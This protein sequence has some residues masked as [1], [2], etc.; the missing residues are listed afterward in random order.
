MSK[1]YIADS[2]NDCFSFFSYLRNKSV[3]TISQNLQIYPR[4]FC[5]IQEEAV[6]S[7]WMLLATPMRTTLRRGQ[8]FPWKSQS[9]WHRTRINIRPW[10]GHTYPKS[11][12]S[13]QLHYAFIGHTRQHHDLIGCSETRT[14]GAHSASALW[15][16]SLE[17]TFSELEFRYDT[18][19]DVI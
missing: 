5:K 13:T 18:I 3:W 8:D 15:P 19:R 17:Y 16:L 7:S 11:Q 1:E 10:C 12:S 4:F 9:E 6:A 14:V 2:R